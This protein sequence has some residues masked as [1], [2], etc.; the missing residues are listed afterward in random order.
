MAYPTGSTSAYGGGTKETIGA[1]RCGHDTKGADGADE[2]LEDH[3]FAV[4]HNHLSPP[5][6]KSQME[7]PYW[8]SP[9][10]SVK[11]GPRKVIL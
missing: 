1:H 6:A 2:P 3:R 11:D 5:M 8:K 7:A 10:N 9:G 4:G